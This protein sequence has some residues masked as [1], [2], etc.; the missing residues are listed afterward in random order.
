MYVSPLSVI[1]G[2]S[3]D[4]IILF[5]SCSCRSPATVNDTTPLHESCLGT[6][7]GPVFP[8]TAL[9]GYDG[10]YPCSVGE[11]LSW[12]CYHGVYTTCFG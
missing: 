11:L 4:S 9:G 3:F 8:W 6:Y 1:S 7:G 10:A 12:L 5:L 2:L